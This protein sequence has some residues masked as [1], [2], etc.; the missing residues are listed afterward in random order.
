MQ[1]PLGAGFDLNLLRATSRGKN[2]NDQPAH[3]HNADTVP[4]GRKDPMAASARAGEVGSVSH[5]IDSA[6]IGAF[7]LRIILF[8]LLA[9]VIEGFD[10]QVLAIAGPLLL[11]EL[12]QDLGGMGPLYSIGLLSFVVGG[13]VL[14]PLGDRIGRKWLLVVSLVAFGLATLVVPV[15]ATI[16]QVMVARFVTGFAFGGAASSFIALP[17]EYVPTRMRGRIV[18]IIWAGMPIGGL[19]SSLSGSALLDSHGWRTLFVIG[20]IFPLLLAAVLIVWLPESIGFLAASGRNSAKIV[21]LLRKIVPQVED[22]KLTSFRSRGPEP[23]VPIRQLFADGRG[24]GSGVI[25][26]ALFLAYMIINLLVAWTPTLVSEA[27][28]PMRIAS[29]SLAVFNGSSLFAIFAFSYALDGR[30]VHSIVGACFVAAAGVVILFAVLPVSAAATMVTVALIGILIG[31]GATGLVAI[32]ALYYPTALRST[33]VGWSLAFARIG[34]ICGP[35]IGSLF[36]SWDLQIGRFFASTALPSLLIA[37][38][39]FLFARLNR[40]S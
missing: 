23:R 1:A 30:H 19:L 6:P 35:L 17:V 31:G 15:L 26:F 22:G 5:L 11:T 9:A 33:G 3:A 2:L 28:V 10:Q 36:F 38:T 8:C 39:V 37:A 21:A 13:M 24:V 12:G 18:A 32:A 7:Q 14:G 29:L 40:S 25:W 34:S 20:G 4:L 16:E 27:G